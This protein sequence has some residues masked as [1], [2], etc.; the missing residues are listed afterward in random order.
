MLT[1]SLLQLMVIP[2]SWSCFSNN[3]Y[4]EK[5]SVALLE[6]NKCHVLV[7]EIP[8]NMVECSVSETMLKMA[9]KTY[10]HINT[11]DHCTASHDRKY[12]KSCTMGRFFPNPRE[13]II[14]IFSPYQ[15]RQV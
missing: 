7:T 2:Q 5:Q 12:L 3:D 11:L 10:K 13:I 15:R 8:E 1:A 9:S 14:L 4:A 6:Y